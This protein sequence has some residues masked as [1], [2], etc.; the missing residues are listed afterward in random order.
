MTSSGR[1]LITRPAIEIGMRTAVL[2]LTGYSTTTGGG[3]EAAELL[4]KYVWADTT[5]QT[6]W[7]Q[8]KRW[9]QFCDEDMRPL[10]PATEGDILA[11]IGYLSLEGRISDTSLPQY[12]SAVSRFHVLHGMPSP[13]STPLIKSLMKPY[14]RKYQAH[15]ENKLQ[16][17]G[18]SAEVMRAILS[19][20]MAASDPDDIASCA[21]SIFSFI[22]HC[23]SVSVSFT[24]QADIRIDDDG[25][26]ATLFR[27]K[28][29]SRL[30][31]LT[32]SYPKHPQSEGDLTPWAL[33]KRWELLR[34][35]AECFFGTTASAKPN[36]VSLHRLL[37]QAL[38]LALCTALDE[39]FYSG[40]SPRIGS[41]NELALLNFPREF[42]MRRLDWESDSMLR[43]YLDTCLLYT[44]PSPR[45]QRGSRMPSSA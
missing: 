45:D 32:L 25:I 26:R 7:S 23:R 15:A 13:T 5:V 40:H 24:G 33:L 10:L 20:G 11:F 22:F 1:R 43:V 37:L 8:L 12:I 19:A 17:I 3:E 27:R 38:R 18:C 6:R 44:S 34:P 39:C 14:A 42:I 29:K 21:A 16:R 4:S 41:Y 9:A 2:T 30:R 28:G 35:S 31:P 36:D